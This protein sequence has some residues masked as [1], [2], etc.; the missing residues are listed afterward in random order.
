MVF[1]GFAARARCARR[2]A[3]ITACAAAQTLR[4]NASTVSSRFAIRAF[5]RRL[6][7]VCA[8]F[9]RGLCGACPALCGVCVAV[10]L[11][12]SRL[13]RLAHSPGM[14]VAA[15]DGAALPC[16][17]ADHRR[18]HRPRFWPG[19]AVWPGRRGGAVGGRPGA[20][21][22]AAQQQAKRLPKPSLVCAAPRTLHSRRWPEQRRTGAF[23]ARPWAAIKFRADGFACLFRR[24]PA[25]YSFAAGRPARRNQTRIQQHVH[26]GPP[27]ATRGPFRGPW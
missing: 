16:A 25:R 27:R 18:Q 26:A 13:Q 8:G 6:C 5:V 10:V 7:G 23:F 24:P 1:F 12:T 4:A 14:H 21:A 17:C 22:G 2:G 3:S 19:D 11:V 20:G 15:G 9:V